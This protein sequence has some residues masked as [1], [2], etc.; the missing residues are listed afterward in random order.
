MGS[1]A[2]GAPLSSTW[3]EGSNQRRMPIGL[4]RQACIDADLTEWQP[5]GLVFRDSSPDGKSSAGPGERVDRV[6]LIPVAHS[7][8]AALGGLMSCCSLLNTLVED[9]G[10]LTCAHR[11]DDFAAS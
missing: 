8:Q 7:P 10:S 1:S 9:V 6:S 5:G 2:K 11:K 4:Q 3:R